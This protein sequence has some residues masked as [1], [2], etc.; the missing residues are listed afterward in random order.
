M[1]R[2]VNPA[3]EEI[4]SEYQEMSFSEMESICDKSY[5]SFVEWKK[6]S[7]GHRADLIKNASSIL[8]KNK[9]K[10]AKLIT[11]EMGKPITQSRGEVEK[12]AWVCDYYYENAE[13][14]LKEVSYNSDFSKSYVKYE[15]LGPIFAIMPWNFP[16]WQV[17]RFAAPN[18][19]AGNT[20]I[21]KHA[22]NT[23]G[24]GIA[25]QE[26]FLEA[27]FPEGVFKTLV[28]GSKPVKEL[29]AN[30]NIRGVT[31]TGSTPVG[32]I[33]A[34]AAGLSMKKTV[35]ELGGSDPYLILNDADIDMAVSACTTG[36][37]INTG[38]SCIAAKRFIVEKGVIDE[39]TEKLTEK[40]EAQITANPL[41]EDTTVGPMARKDL[42]EEL[43]WQV[44]KSIEKGAEQ[45]FKGIVS[46]TKGY[47]FAPHILANVK[48]GMPAFDEELF[49]PVASVIEAEN[50]DVAVQ[51]ANMSEFGLGAAVF[52]QDVEK[53]IK[54]ADEIESGNVFINDFVKSDPRLPFGGTKMS[55]YGRELSDLGIREFLNA[56]TICVR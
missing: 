37:L 23:T 24:S 9:E 52:S 43:E 33:V 1:I 49:G 56:K 11:D 47:Y 30:E 39:F 16:F 38:Q 41:S 36:R 8:R 20:G 40:F 35:F 19:V 22:S 46:E 53:A 7:L 42:K 12:C 21:L 15:P 14:H 54:I 31:L 29:I 4:L 45:V 51:L 17:F 55:G 5:K 28:T 34:H 10:Y 44:K 25:I 26:I 18:L 2:T 50:T 32:K 13:R 27:G 6:K 3:N 48:P